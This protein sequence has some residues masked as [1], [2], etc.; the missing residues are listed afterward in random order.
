VRNRLSPAAATRAFASGRHRVI[1]L[2]GVG[3]PH[4]GVPDSEAPYWLPKE[5]FIAVLDR[6]CDLRD[7]GHDI[8]LTFDD[9][10]LSDLEIAAPE[11]AA[12]GF[13]AEFFVLTGR[14]DHPR[15]LAPNQLHEMSRLGMAI[16]LHG[17]GHVDWR[18]VGD[19]EMQRETVASRRVLEDIM[20]RPITRV[21]IP[22]GSYNRGVI[23]RL[24]VANFEAI[25]TSDG[26]SALDQERIKAR[27]TLRSDMSDARIEQILQGQ[28]AIKTRAR[29]LVST[30][31]R[32]N[33]I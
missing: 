20:G 30:T 6:I 32:Q 10:N 7:Q 25:Y 33:V 12:R 16:G 13:S 24:E 22:F 2:H 9:G 26:G 27:S 23:A 14:L 18:R 21:A 17:H 19:E 29:R 15:Y 8:R 5:R 28:D 11:I 1:N 4:D 3:T 31:L